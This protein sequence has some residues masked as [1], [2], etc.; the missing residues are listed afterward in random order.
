MQK[1]QPA[2]HRNRTVKTAQLDQAPN[3]TECTARAI[4]PMAEHASG[5]QTHWARWSGTC[6]LSTN[7]AHQPA[8]PWT[9]S[10][11]TTYDCAPIA[12]CHMCHKTDDT[13]N[14]ASTTP[15]ASTHQTAD[16]Q[17]RLHRHQHNL[18][19]ELQGCQRL[20]Q[21][22]QRQTY[23]PL[24]YLSHSHTHVCG[25]VWVFEKNFQ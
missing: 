17:H 21:Q 19:D 13:V 24:W 2:K 16:E 4:N 14:H 8:G 25:C 9:S 11:T 15:T 12:T 20:Q 3:P 6:E 7:T 10:T 5:M 18:P 22:E 1:T 23:Q